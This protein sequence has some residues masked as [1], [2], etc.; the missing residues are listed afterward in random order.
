[1]NLVD[2]AEPGHLGPDGAFVTVIGF[3][4][5]LD[6]MTI[7]HVALGARRSSGQTTIQV[8][9]PRDFAT[10]FLFLPHFV[11]VTINVPNSS[12]SFLSRLP[13]QTLE[14]IKFLGGQAVFVHR[15]RFLRSI[16]QL[17]PHVLS[18]TPLFAV[19]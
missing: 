14:T 5:F 15:S 10:L 18:T 9:G 17:A 11:C 12:R 8:P 6:S 13:N 2:R 19:P 4:S 16:G 7:S 3:V 1:M